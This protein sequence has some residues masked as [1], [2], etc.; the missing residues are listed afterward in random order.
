MESKTINGV[1]YKKQERDYFHN[2]ILNR[3]AGFFSLWALGV[4]AVISGNFFGWNLGLSSSGFGGLFIATILITVMFFGLSFCL[5]ELSPALPHSG[6]AYSFARTAF[7]PWGGLLAGMADT[8]KYVLTPAVIVVGIGHYMGTIF[9]ELFEI[10]LTDQLWW[11]ISYALFIGLNIISTRIVFALT[12]VF[13]FLAL[14]ILIVF[15][16][17][18]LP[19][20]SLDHA[21]NFQPASPDAS[22]WLPFGW[23]GV[24][25]ALPFAIWFFLA[26][27]QIPLASEEA[28][29][30][31]RDVP[32]A[33]IVGLLTL[34]VVAFLT[35]FLNAGIPPGAALIGKST[36]PLLT[37]FKSLHGD[38]IG[39]LIL[40]L[41][42]VIGLVASF[43]TII[44]AYGRN[45][46]S[47]SRAGY[48]PKFLS[49]T[50]DERGTPYIGLVAGGI[51]GYLVAILVQS[52]TAIFGDMET[53][54][55]LLNMA[56]FAALISYSLQ[57]LSFIAIRRKLP[58]IERPY[59]S[60]LGNAGAIVTIAIAVVTIISMLMVPENIPGLIG[61]LIWFAVG[62]VYY[63][64]HARHNMVLSPEEEYAITKGYTDPGQLDK[65]DDTSQKT[66]LSGT[67]AISQS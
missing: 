5:A 46:F 44:Y 4:A 17:G 38:G 25:L 33:L 63:Q 57:C 14:G 1:T 61:C 24:F 11:L 7:G 10:R 37:A 16:V 41:I 58:D 31:V 18:A 55:V 52:R 3:Q 65:P 32:R 40:S 8:I 28:R 26:I 43:H 12:I 2:R 39:S 66:G 13:T 27:E 22:L 45:I 20:F 54:A 53:G 67:T 15:W 56:V 60:P 47:L 34:V 50:L 30:P 9:E 23:E 51:A 62:G 48:Y 19:Y 6:A 49:L 35:L 42:A 36:E 64:F 29:D 21:L 59:K